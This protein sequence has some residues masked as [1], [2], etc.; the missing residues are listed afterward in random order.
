MNAAAVQIDPSKILLEELA[1]LRNAKSRRQ[2]VRQHR[3]DLSINLVVQLA[4]K[5]RPLLRINPRNSLALSETAIEIARVLNHDL[6]MAHAKRM[7]ANAEYALGRYRAAVSL[8]TT[9]IEL[10]ESL[11]EKAELGR[12]LSV[13]ILSLNLCAEYEKAFHC[14]E[15][16][17]RIFSELNDDLRLARVDINLG[18]VF[19]RQDRFAE[20]LSCYRRAYRVVLEHRDAEGIGVVLSNLA[21]CLIS[22][23]EFS[24]AL[25]TYQEAREVCSKHGMPRLVAQADY[26]IAYLHYLRGEYSRAIEM[27]R[28]TRS[29][30]LELEDR[31]HHALCNLD[32]S[33]LYVELNLSGDAIDL[34]RHARD[35]FKTLRMGYEQAKAI[36]FEAMAMSQIGEPVRSLRLFSQ[37]RKM[38]VKERNRVW[39]SLIDLYKAVVLFNEG[40]GEEAAVLANAALEFFES[41]LLSGKAVLCRLLL[42]RIAQGHG[43]LR[44]AQSHCHAALEKLRNLQ[45]PVLKHQAFLLMGQIHAALQAQQ[46]AYSC[47]RASRY[48]LELLRTNVRGQELKLAFLK[49]RLEVYEML[50]RTCLQNPSESSLHEA[51]G[52]I[53][54][55][56]SRVLMA[57]MLQP[58]SK[59]TSA[60]ESSEGTGEIEKL[61]KELNLYYNLIELEQLRLESRSPERVNRLE[62][63]VRVRE[64]KLLRML[65][66]STSH[67][68]I[69]TSKAGLGSVALEQIRET[70]PEDTLILEYFQAGNDVLACILCGDRLEIKAVTSSVRFSDALRLLR[71]QFSKFR[72][73]SEYTQSFRDCLLESTYSHLKVLYDELLAPIHGSLNT[74]NLIIVPHGVLHYVPFHALWDGAAFLLDKYTVSYAP[75]ASV[76]A[77]CSRRKA[78]GRGD[79]LVMGIPDSRAPFIKDEVHSIGSILEG[80]QTHFGC[81]ATREVL[82]REGP[83]SRIVHIATHGRFRQDNPI[84]S[85]I[86]LGDSYLNLYDIYG[87]RLPVELVTLSGCATGM[88][89]VTAG[90]EL[91]GLA[92]GLFQAGANSLVL[93]L[94]DAHDASTAEFMRNFYT[95]LGQGLSRAWALKQA[96]REVRDRWPHP[97][98]WA[99]FVLMGAHDPLPRN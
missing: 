25:Q 3:Q 87:L 51:F 23:E 15:R 63:Q 33:E 88:N 47:F 76:Y 43:D 27:L 45:S 96:M 75:S 67:K 12:T 10:F 9:A 61:R 55:A 50:V 6:A 20:A 8:Y 13:S 46:D 65:R 36:A 11:G 93:S 17:R 26:N 82:E 71:F 80:A 59:E 98:H 7:K 84:F 68:S 94:W 78:H 31:Y 64:S 48:H 42:A 66:E 92:R 89:S 57:E 90:D 58:S 28:S 5:G 60:K 74:S 56:K 99:S 49:N 29:A 54:E 53:E 18:N 16:A 39:P 38:F 91:I 22:I 62:S 14:A 19:H 83:G 35:E 77:V 1:E 37:A 81:S 73:G 21:V 30:C 41:S 69:E 4:D 95:G 97:Y 40:R 52:Y 32:L 79:A 86:R 44:T 34:T 24:E 72:L 70:L 85:A 2:Y